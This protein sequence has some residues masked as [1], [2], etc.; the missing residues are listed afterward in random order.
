[1]LGAGLCWS[2]GGIFVRSVSEP[3]SWEI[4]FWRSLSMGVFLFVWLSL[5]YAGRVRQA[6]VAIG[7]GGFLAGLCLSLAFLGFILAVTQTTV[8][9][10]LVI[11]STSPFLAALLG[12]LFLGEMV[13]LRSYIAMG[14][15]LTGIAAMCL[16]SLTAG[17]LVGNLLSG[18]VAVAFAVC[19]ILLRQ[20]RAR[21]D[22]TPAVLLRLSSPRVSPSP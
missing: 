14:I 11:M 15:A 4:A 5:R 9:N 16:D 10:A 8:A 1:M 12:R 20:S 18:G 17:T 22:M 19:V 6:V 3:N 21:A 13:P 7:P 2:T